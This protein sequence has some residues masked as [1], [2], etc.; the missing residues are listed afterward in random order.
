MGLRRFA[1]GRD[2]RLL[3]ALEDLGPLGPQH[4][5]LV[6]GLALF[7]FLRLRLTGLGV[8]AAAHVAQEQVALLR[9]GCFFQEM[10]A[11]FQVGLAALGQIA[12]SQ[13]FEQ[14]LLDQR[15]PPSVRRV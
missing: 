3:I 14:K 10:S 7:L 8:E 6:V 11:R 4:R 9:A 12:A 2:A 1:V 5:Q 15:Q 13:A